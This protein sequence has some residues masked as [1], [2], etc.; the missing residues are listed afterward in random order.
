[1]GALLDQLWAVQQLQSELYECRRE[2]DRL[3]AQS[4]DRRKKADELK[5]ALAA[6]REDAKRKQVEMRT[7][8]TDSRTRQE[9]IQ[10]LRVKLNMC[11]NQR[12]Y[13]ALLSEIASAEAENGRLTERFVKLDEELRALT[14]QAAELEVQVKSEEA[15]AAALDARAAGRLAE[16]GKRLTA[17]EAERTAKLAGVPAE[18]RRAF[19]RLSERY[20]G[21]AMVPIELVDDGEAI[22]ACT[23][24]NMSLTAG[25]TSAVFSIDEIRTCPTCSKILYHAG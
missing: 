18:A 25:V 6:R 9:Q 5:K 22:Y 2:R 20:E 11:R 14:T 12:D 7:C 23:H 21:Q 16:I 15:A 10:G 4:A 24:C 1:M 3:T 13:A 19:D 8:E 17:L